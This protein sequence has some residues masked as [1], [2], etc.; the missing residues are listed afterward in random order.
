MI[1]LPFM[2]IQAA[3]Y[4]RCTLAISGGRWF[5]GLLPLF[6]NYK[7]KT[8]QP[9]DSIFRISIPSFPLSTRRSP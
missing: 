9:G 6:K 5:D 1:S 8:L 7:Y 3:V 2:G 4:G